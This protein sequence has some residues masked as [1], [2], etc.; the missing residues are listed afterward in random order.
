M[1]GWKSR[2]LVQGIDIAGSE[3]YVGVRIEHFKGNL[4]HVADACPPAT[5][6]VWP[7]HIRQGGRC[8]RNAFA[9]A[10]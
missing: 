2:A 5:A 8:L 3:E 6:H 7:N 10:F 4:R 9:Y 1:R